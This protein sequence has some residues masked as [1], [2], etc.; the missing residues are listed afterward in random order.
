[1]KRPVRP[2]LLRL[3]PR[4]RELRASLEG[5][6]L[7]SDP[8]LFPH[9]YPD[10][11]DREI[12]AFL[13]ASLAFGRVASIRTSLERLLGPLGA[14]PARRIREG[15]PCPAPAG[16]VHRWVGAAD[17]HALL[18]ALGR[19]LRRHGSLEALLVSHDPGGPDYVPA[20]D[21]AYRELRDLTGVPAAQLSRGLKFL[22]PELARGGA[23]K[24]AH[25]FLRWMVRR[26]DVDLGVFR[27]G[28]FTP[29]RLLV[30]MD[31]HVHRIAR[32][33]HLTRRRTADLA[34][35]R[36]VTGWLRRIDPSDPVSFDWALCHHGILAACTRQPRPDLCARCVLRPACG[37][38]VTDATSAGTGR[39]RR[40][41]LPVSS[42]A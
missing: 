11:A 20:L 18:L 25:L 28:G 7:E 36:E 38:S 17:I 3:G 42:A 32:Y 2:D 23:C 41:A 34:A 19:A 26:R 24:R 12:V 33:L 29:E 15:G 37:A 9:R 35:S 1:V 27:S 14:S 40:P 21:G 4:L 13:A 39:S 22:L 31:T 30:P 5:R 6:G 10:P 16:F 8:L